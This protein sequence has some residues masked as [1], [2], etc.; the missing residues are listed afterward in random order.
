MIMKKKITS[1]KRGLPMENL[2]DEL[3]KALLQVKTKSEMARF[4]SDLCT[5]QE[6]SAMAERWH[7]CQ[8]LNKGTL[9][10][11]AISDET[12]VSLATITRVARFLH[13]EPEQGYR[14]ILDRMYTKK[15]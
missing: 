4:L 1:Q 10:Y 11:R 6:I 2:E 3:Y 7:V 5:P 9:S 8:L 12:G 14:T 15:D 13:T